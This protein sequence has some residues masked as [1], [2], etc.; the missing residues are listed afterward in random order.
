MTPEGRRQ[1]EELELL[2]RKL[3]EKYEAGIGSL[4]PVSNPE[5]AAMSDEEFRKFFRIA[6]QFKSDIQANTNIYR[7]V[8]EFVHTR[9]LSSVA[10]TQGEAGLLRKLTAGSPYRPSKADAI[11]EAR[12]RGIATKRLKEL[13]QQAS[14][15]ILRWRDLANQSQVLRLDHYVRRPLDY[16]KARI[17]LHLLRRELQE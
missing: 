3:E 12:K 16:Y 11:D 1:M 9:I 2:H 17:A 15:K 7:A 8:R 10:R 14:E 6:P 5:I 13:I 4:N